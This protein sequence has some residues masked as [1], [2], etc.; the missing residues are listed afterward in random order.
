[1]GQHELCIYDKISFLIVALLAVLASVTGK[2]QLAVVLGY[3]LFGSLWLVSCLTKEPLCAA[4][5]KYSYGENALN[6]PIF[7]RTNYRIAVAWG[8]LY[9]LTAGWTLLLSGR[10]P[11]LVLI[12][13]NQTVPILLGLFTAWFQKWYPAKIASGK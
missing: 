10:V 9:I 11:Y 4:Y 13:L 7:M 1:M 6:N 3:F 8:V 2:G 12:L 5:V